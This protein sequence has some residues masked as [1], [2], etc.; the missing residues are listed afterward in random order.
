LCKHGR[1]QQQLQSS[2]ETIILYK[3]EV[4]IQ[5][6]PNS[7]RYKL[8][9]DGEI[10][11]NEWVPSPSSIVGKLDKSQALIP[12][13]VGC[14]EKKVQELMRD[15]VN[16]SKDDVL[17]MLS[18]GREAHK[19]IKDS[20]CNVGD[21][22]HKYAENYSSG[23]DEI[24]AEFAELDDSEQFKVNAGIEAFKK[25]I[26]DSK[27]KFI[28]TECVVY[29]RKEKFVG[30]F[31]ALVEIDG[32]KYILDYKTSKSVY[33]SHFYQVSAYLKAWEEERGEKLAGGMI[34][35]F[36]KDDVIKNEEVI[37]KAGESKVVTMSRSD[38][39]KGYVGFKALN[40]IYS[41][42][43]EVTKQLYENQKI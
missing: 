15:G 34:V 39:V 1:G 5:F 17:A 10:S 16:F 31:D 3:G 20:A 37:M 2:M 29:S 4:G 30:T 13:A 9:S 14:F 19:N 11:P 12:W 33:T 42:D 8:I 43:K 21:I 6:Y 24:P 22:V 36:C 32:K 28:E 7:H 23:K 25:W 27:P 40:T 38:L 35:L 18:E 26:A 41:I